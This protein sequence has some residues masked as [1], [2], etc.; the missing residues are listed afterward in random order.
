[1]NPEEAIT[2]SHEEAEVVLNQCFRFGRNALL[3]GAHGTGKTSMIQKV[4]SQNGLTI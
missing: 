2:V 4:A 1:M 3:V